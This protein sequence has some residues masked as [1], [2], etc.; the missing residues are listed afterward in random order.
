MSRT[1]A[2]SAI[3]GLVGGLLG[4]GVMSV[5]HSVVGRL[6]PAK[7][8]QAALA[9][10]DEDATVKIGQMISRLG[11]GRSLNEDEKPMAATAVHYG[12]GGVLGLMYG[13]VAA[14]DP[15]AAVGAG[16]GF[17]VA[18]WLGPHAIVVP[19]LGLAPSPLRQP[20]AKEALELVLHVLYGITV[21]FVRRLF[22]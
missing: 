9:E 5:A 4:A 15:R 13:V 20:P 7:P 8:P 1:V 11:R 18:A 22:Y 14:L 16:V 10:K 3:A 19:A 17:G 2:V 21:Q 12:F 6:Q